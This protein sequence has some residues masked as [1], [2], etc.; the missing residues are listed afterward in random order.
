MI[1]KGLP[2]FKT[3]IGTWVIFGH[4]THE[5][6]YSHS[7][8]KAMSQTLALTERLAP[9]KLWILPLSIHP[10]KVGF[11][12]DNV[13]SSLGS[14]YDTAFWTDSCHATYNITALPE[15][16]GVH[17]LAQLQVFL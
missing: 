13:V 16:L 8:Q 10:A 15:H 11:P 9:L 1:S 12:S 3:S 4:V 7:I 6:S 17:S 2:P 5:Q 14:I